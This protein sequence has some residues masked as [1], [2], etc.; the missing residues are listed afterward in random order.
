MSESQTPTCPECGAALSLG[1]AEGLC[2]RCLLRAG[3]ESE[4]VSDAK[5]GSSVDYRSPTII[6]TGF[7]PPTPEEIQPLFPHLAILE[8]LGKGG[9]GAVYK[10]R[11]HSLDRFVAV[12]ILP[13]NVAQDPAFAERF[14]REAKALARLNHPHIVTVHDVGRAEKLYYFVMEYV[15]GANLRELIRGGGLTPSQALAIVP[16]ICDA[17]QY[18]HDEGIVHRDIKPENVLLDAKGRVKIADFGLAKLLGADRSD[19]SLTGTHQV[20]GTLRYMAPEQVQGSRSVDHRA[21]IYALGV[22]FYELLTGEVPMGR[23]APPSRKVQVDIRLDEVVLR[24]LESEPDKRYQRV[25]EMKQDTEEICS[26]DPIT[27]IPQP[28]QTLRLSERSDFG[29]VIGM[30]GTALLGSAACLIF[31]MLVLKSYDPHNFHPEI[32]KLLWLGYIFA[33]F[34]ILVLVGTDLTNRIRNRG[35]RRD[36]DLRLDKESHGKGHSLPSR[37]PV[38]EP[39]HRLIQNVRLARRAI[40][41]SLL[42]LP[43]LF[44]LGA[45]GI[46]QLSTTSFGGVWPGLLMLSP[47]AVAACWLGGLAIRD[48]RS[49]SRYGL[50]LAVFDVLVLPLAILNTIV[51]FVALMVADVAVD[52]TVKPPEIPADVVLRQQHESQQAQLKAFNEQLQIEQAHAQRVKRRTKNIAGLIA[53]P[54]GLL[55]NAWIVL[56]VWRSLTKLHG[57]PVKL[58]PPAAPVD[59]EAAERRIQKPMAAVLVVGLAQVIAA[60][61]LT[62]W[63]GVTLARILSAPETPE[64]KTNASAEGSGSMTS[65]QTTAIQPHPWRPDVGAAKAMLFLNIFSLFVGMFAV[66]AAVFGSRLEHE[67]L[68]RVSCGLLCCPS[69]VWPFALPVA[70]SAFGVLGRPHIKQAFAERAERDE[71]DDSPPPS[72]LS[73]SSVWTWVGVSFAMLGAAASVLPW[74]WLNILGLNATMIGLDGWQGIIVGVVSGLAAVLIFGFALLGR[75]Q[76][77]QGLT[78]LIAGIAIISSAG[79]FLWQSS[80][81]PMTTAIQS[82]DAERE[83]LANARIGELLTG[84]QQ[85]PAFGVHFAL[86]CGVSL[87]LVGLGQL[88]V[89]VIAKDSITKTTAHDWPTWWQTRPLALRR[90]VRGSLFAVYFLCLLMFFT[91]STSGLISFA[92]AQGQITGARYSCT[93][94]APEPWFVVERHEGGHSSTMKLLSPTLLLI[95]A[96]CVS[97]GLHYRL[98]VIETEGTIGIWEHPSTQ[99]VLWGSLAIIGVLVANV[100][101]FL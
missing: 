72:I 87:V 25:S 28:A 12:K 84:I 86:A 26:S 31:G 23:F 75:S 51:V 69:V 55:L 2:P 14:T 63:L 39:Q 48:I 54:F 91:F 89:P 21:D 74:A 16:Q 57:E 97:Y 20:M 101:L 15:D 70:L 5:S 4:P 78:A 50:P 41:G 94:G 58:T 82:S 59:V 10:A 67:G 68:V 8:L 47:L 61:I 92:D 79:Q 49:G 36:R 1:R 11:Q 19:V 76:F 81:P 38:L 56:R 46:E 90:C 95:L 43:F 13:P 42:A 66:T 93:I 45:V 27:S 7:V 64:T 73:R 17:L 29:E 30:A 37:Q 96:A 71:A 35:K 53:L 100:P 22:V 99:A 60:G 34:G 77:G 83:A 80:Q 32:D 65:R 98:R 88:L 18:A 9:M 24:A 3:F 62:A 40:I 6:E 85:A 44:I 33:G 52:V